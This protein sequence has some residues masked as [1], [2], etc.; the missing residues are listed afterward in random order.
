LASAGTVIVADTNN[1]LIRLLDPRAQRLTTLALSSV[2]PPRRSPGGPPAGGT[3]AAAEPPPGAALVRSPGAVTVAVGKLQL[4]F[5]LP[6]G[7]HL[8]PGANS[9]FEAMVLGG[10]A[11]GV[12]LQPTAGSLR[13]DASG[14]TATA[15]LSFSRQL[16]SGCGG[17]IRVLCKVYFCQDNDVC[18]FQEVCFDVPLAEAAAG[19]AASADV[20]LS[21]SLSAQAPV[22]SLPG[23]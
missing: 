22:V 14:S 12:Q 18:L 21:F 1:S 7:Y 10:E 9:R 2:P 6:R 4:S 13:E 20:L 5:Q 3:A 16:G 8:T 17:L 11:V 19:A 23:L 15:A